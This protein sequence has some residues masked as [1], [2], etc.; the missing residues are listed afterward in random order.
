MARPGPS[1]TASRKWTR[2]SSGR[3]FSRR[4]MPSQSWSSAFSGRTFSAASKCVMASSHWA[5]S[6]RADR[7][8]RAPPPSRGRARARGGSSRWPPP[9]CPAWPARS[10]AGS[11]PSRSPAGR[12][13]RAR[14]GLPPRRADPSPRAHVPTTC[15]CRGRW[16]RERGPDESARWPRRGRPAPGGEPASCK[17]ARAFF[18]PTATA[19]AAAVRAASRFPSAAAILDICRWQSANPGRCRSMSSHRARASAYFFS[20]TSLL[21]R[22]SLPEESDQVLGVLLAAV[23]ALRRRVA[24]RPR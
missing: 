18:G 22:W 10:R 21:R 24:A 19:L 11:R 7:D 14:A 13:R 12:R 16:D 3:P 5:P 17:W 4:A 15:A 1:L 8:R 6:A 9:A 20:S 2:A 23:E